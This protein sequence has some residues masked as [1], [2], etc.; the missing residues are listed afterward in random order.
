M[1]EICSEDELAS[2]LLESLGIDA[3]LSSLYT[4]YPELVLRPDLAESPVGLFAIPERASLMAVPSRIVHPLLRWLQFRW[5]F[6]LLIVLT[7]A[8]CGAAPNNLHRL[9]PV[10]CATVPWSTPLVLAMGTPPPAH[11][12]YQLA[13]LGPISLQSHQIQ[14]TWHFG[15]T[16]QF[17]WCPFVSTSNDIAWRLPEVLTATL[18]GPFPSFAAANAARPM[19]GNGTPP[20]LAQS[21]YGP[22]VASATPIHTDTWAGTEEVSTIPLPDTLVAGYYLFVFNT[23]IRPAENGPLIGNG[24]GSGIVKISG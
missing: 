11:L 8:S 4:F 3:H 21:L 18:Q 17:D 20:E 1:R 2:K 9:S 6:G 12:T 16:M 22:V 14:E 13:L 23:I 7:L 5:V 24:P 19:P 10:S 15:D